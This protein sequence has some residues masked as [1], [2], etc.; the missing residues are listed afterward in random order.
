MD[1]RALLEAEALDLARLAGAAYQRAVHFYR[2]EGARA[3]RG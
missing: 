3:E 1:S 2:T